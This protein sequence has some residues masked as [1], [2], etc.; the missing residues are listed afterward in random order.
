MPTGV[1]ISETIPRANEMLSSLTTALL[2]GI[3]QAIETIR[4][5]MQ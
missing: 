4:S 3:D 1:E 5:R 2:R